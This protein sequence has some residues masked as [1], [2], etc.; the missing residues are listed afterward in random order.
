MLLAGLRGAPDAER[1]RP[2]SR[3]RGF[4]PGWDRRQR[5]FILPM[6]LCALRRETG[7]AQSKRGLQIHLTALFE[8]H[9]GRT[10]LTI[11]QRFEP[12]TDVEANLKMGEPEGWG[13]S[14][15]RLA[16]YVAVTPKS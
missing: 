6:R 2:G 11:V 5:A 15:D 4:G 10:K 14:L 7:A 9:A 16:E 12:V 1:G 3:G 13:G 8:D